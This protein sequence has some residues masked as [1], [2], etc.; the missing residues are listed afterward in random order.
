MT[1]R[2]RVLAVLAAAGLAQAVSAQVDINWNAGSGNW[3]V[4]ANWDPVNVPN[5]QSENALILGPA[6]TVVTVDGVFSIHGLRVA[7]LV[8]LLIDP[9]RTLTLN[10]DLLNDGLIDLNPTSS[11]NNAS[12][13]F[14]GDAT[15]SGSG[16]IRLS[17]GG[18]D[19]QLGTINA[20]VT[21]AA[22]H[23]IGGAGSIFADLINDGLVSAFETGFGNILQLSSL[24][25]INNGAMRAETGGVLEITGITLTQGPGGLI[26]S[27]A[28]GEV[29][30]TGAQTIIGGTLDGPG[31][32]SRPTGATTLEGVALTGDLAVAPL[33]TVV[34]DGGVF[35][36]SG[37][38]TL[39]DSSSANNGVLQFNGDTNTSGGG[40][41]FLAGGGDDSQVN[42][43]G[44]VLTLASGFTIEGSGQVSADLVNNGLV[45]AFPST[46]GDGRLRLVTNNK[47][48]NAQIVADPG[49][50]IE[51]NGITIT[52][53]ASGEII[54]DGGLVEF[55]GS[56]SIVGGTLRGANGG[57]MSRA[58]SGTLTLNNAAVDTVLNVAALGAV[59]SIGDAFVCSGMIVLNDS[60]SANNAVL[61]FSADATASGGGSVFLAGGGDDSQVNT[62]ASVLTIASDFTVGGSG[63]IAANLVNNG[64]VR[65][66]PSTSGDGR[67]RLVTNDKVNHAQIVAETGGVIELNG[68]TLTQNSEGGGPGVL[69]ADG[70]TVE[71]IASQAVNGG[72][73]DATNGGRLVRAASGTL[74]LSDITLGGILEV[75]P[76]STVV[77]QSEVFTN[78]GAV[79]LN[80]TISANNALFQFLNDTTVEGDGR[81]VLAG[82]SDD[83]QIISTGFVA[84]FGAGQTIEGVGTMT[85]PFVIGGTI[86]PGLP[87][88]DIDGVGATTLTP[89]AVLD[90]EASGDPGANDR[91][92]RN[93][94]LD[95]AGTLRFRFLDGFTPTVFPAVYTVAI[96][97]SVAGEFDALDLP[98]PIQPGSAVYVG[99]DSTRVYVAFT[100]LADNAPPF[101]TLDL[102][103]ITGFINGF[104]NNTPAADLAPP[105]GFWDL[106]DITAFVQAFTAG[107]D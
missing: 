84:T 47:V 94:S 63:T 95:L 79:V 98:G 14:N 5:D 81:F 89:S 10:G 102:A 104:L 53:G 22:G 18:D 85:G 49:G 58:V 55:A 46:N 32:I 80:D 97:Q 42:T 68:I 62:N 67:L 1:E 75:M 56:Q 66:F 17:G 96:A 34:V 21:H 8:T 103:D 70:G 38:V 23:T 26:A 61:V 31:L 101:G 9:V 20:V 73:L 65:A 29:R 100:C 52:Q 39:N 86:A 2:N 28:G 91:L 82:G 24:N 7:P 77:Y 93:G 105:F 74:T 44:G 35:V 3:S 69:V 88:G 106:A 64:L 19:A 13:R 4:A 48:N 90:I 11:G 57:V 87:V 60:L 92:N 71:F 45:R 41:V 33:G 25:K 16:L 51:V 76:L 15:I 27:E 107:C 37:T 78:N 72:V 50:I 83:S 6:S 36:C 12:L 54:A 30:L 43:V 40:S 99:A 59:D